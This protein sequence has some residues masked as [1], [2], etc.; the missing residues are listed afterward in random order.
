MA[1]ASKVGDFFCTVTGDKNVIAME[2]IEAMKDGVIIA[3]SGHFDVEIDLAALHDRVGEGRSV[4]PQ[5]QAY[6]LG[7]GRTIHVLSQGRLVNLAAAEGHPSAVMDMS[8][9][10]Q[11]L[12]TEHLTKLAEP[13]AKEVYRAPYEI[14][15]EVGRLKLQSMGINIDS[16]TV[17]QERYMQSWEIGT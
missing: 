13:L 11:A 14:D 7:D 17:E 5:V 8:F 10:N 16:A 9:A 4:R 15:A 12:V 6:D 2:H 1:E 3:N